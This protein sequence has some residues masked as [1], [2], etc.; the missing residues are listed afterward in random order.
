MFLKYNFLLSMVHFMVSLEKIFLYKT[1]GPCTSLT[2]SYRRN[3]PYTDPAGRLTMWKI[4]VQFHRDFCS[5][6][7]VVF[8]LFCFDY[9]IPSGEKTSVIQNFKAGSLWL[10][11]N[12]TKHTFIRLQKKNYI[13]FNRYKP[14]FC[15]IPHLFM[16][17]KTSQQTRNKWNLIGKTYSKHHI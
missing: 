7:L 1:H 8:V 15:Y 2:F 11:K 9:L 3:R 12:K 14:V 6:F 17:F 5:V 10:L 16:V 4:E 13:T